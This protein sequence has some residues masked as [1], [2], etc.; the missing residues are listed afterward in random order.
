M[1]TLLFRVVTIKWLQINQSLLCEI[2]KL[3]ENF[4]VWGLKIL[5]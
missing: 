5:P 3:A 2:Y 4:F 1:I